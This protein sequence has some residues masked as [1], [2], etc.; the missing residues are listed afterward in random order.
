MERKIL[1]SLL[2][3]D[4][5]A[6]TLPCCKPRIIFPWW[7]GMVFRREFEQSSFE[8]LSLALNFGSR[9]LWLRLYPA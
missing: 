7:V 9:G 4:G 3:G 2:H 8:Q 1:G 6:T 5:N